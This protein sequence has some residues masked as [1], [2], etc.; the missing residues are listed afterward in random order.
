MLLSL[1]RP[2]FLRKMSVEGLH[3]LPAEDGFC[4]AA[5]HIDYLDGF[6][7]AA[8]FGGGRPRMVHFL[9]ETRNYWWTG[10]TIPIN[11]SRKS[12]ALLHAFTAIRSG[13]NISFFCEGR[14]NPTPVLLPGKTGCARLAFWAGKPVVPVGITGPSGRNFFTS[15]CILLFRNK[16]VSIRIGAPITVNDL[17]DAGGPKESMVLSTLRIMQAIAPLCGKTIAEERIN[18]S[19]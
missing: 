17:K 3:H 13:Q 5:N 19:V 7:L 1:L 8:A 4:I 11:R 9:T 2:L 12:D 6:F 14:R 16:P 18:I 15:C 10:A